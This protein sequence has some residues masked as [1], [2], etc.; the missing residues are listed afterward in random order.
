MHMMG[1][2]RFLKRVFD[3]L[4]A[5]AIFVVLAIPFFIIAILIRIDSRG[6]IFFIQER[7]GKDGKVFR[8]LKFRTMVE[9]A[10]NMGRGI[11]VE[12]NDFRITW[13][14][15]IL[16][17]FGIDELPQLFHILKGEMSFVGPR[18]ALP[19][20]AAQYSASER[21]RLLVKPG[22]ANM[23]MLKGWNTLSWKERIRWDVWYI[24]HWSIF[25]DLK[26]LFYTAIIVLLG[27]GQYGAKG[28]VEDYK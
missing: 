9:N 1:F 23:A 5:L 6:P 16:R 10:V 8:M 13:V 11:E 2:Q 15:R 12:Q 24:E 14:G 28:V 21:K 26:I 20:Q 18:P 3:L 22:I 25:L 27:K 17:R 4:A 19:H 7:V